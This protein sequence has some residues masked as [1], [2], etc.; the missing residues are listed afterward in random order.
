MFVE[1]NYVFVFN[2]HHGERERKFCFDKGGDGY[3]TIGQL[4]HRILLQTFLP[5]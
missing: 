5:I 1:L 3:I 2:G 4:P